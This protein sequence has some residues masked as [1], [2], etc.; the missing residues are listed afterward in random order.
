MK[1]IVIP[2]SFKGTLTSL[3]VCEIIRQNLAGHNVITIPAAD[4][5]EGTLDAFY[6][7]KAAAPHL[8]VRLVSAPAL[9][10]SGEEITAPYLMAGTTAVIETAK[11][12]GFVNASPSGEGSFVMTSTTFG[13]GM[14]IRDAISRGARKIIVGLGGS[15]TN[16]GGCGMAAAL[17][18]VFSSS[19][20]ARFTPTGGTLQEISFIDN[21][22]TIRL[23]ADNSNVF[24]SGIDIVG[25]CDVTNPLLG[26]EGA[27]HVFA[28]QKG[29]SPEEVDI[30]EAGLA[31]LVSIIGDDSVIGTVT[32][33]TL[34]SVGNM[35]PGRGSAM[36]LA[37]LPGS[38]A[39]GG[40][41]FGIRAL[42][43]GRLERGIE[44]LL[45]T[46]NFDDLLW[47]ADLVI[48][49]EGRFDSQSLGGKAVSGIC[50]RAREAGVPVILLAGTA[51]ADPQKLKDLGIIKCFEAGPL[52]FSQPADE[53][54]KT[55]FA[56]MQR[57]AWELNEY[58]QQ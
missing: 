6:H 54:K 16:D 49:G 53:I 46:I 34:N 38:G 33:A 56:N 27:A 58:L 50:K 8:S 5:G 21:S 42:L 37:K 2:D 17:G 39:A 25:M 12:A 28:P 57:A 14:L 24:R 11:V 4:G 36:K 1:I 47:D 45:D 3:E 55:A 29:A 10:C 41:G 43:G 26:P 13:V 51:K 35:V 22:Q 44:L 32:G 18:T 40:M 31:N 23:L 9:N 15:C 30:L 7:A 52:D 20:G 48:T 19:S